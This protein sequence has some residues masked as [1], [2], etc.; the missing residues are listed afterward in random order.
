MAYPEMWDFLGIQV[1]RDLMA[2]L[3][4]QVYLAKRWVLSIF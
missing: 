1:A 4:T 3:A 2:Y